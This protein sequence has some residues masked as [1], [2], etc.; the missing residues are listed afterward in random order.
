MSG[1]LPRQAQRGEFPWPVASRLV[2][3]PSMVSR[4]SARG[5]LERK[6]TTGSS[7]AAPGW[8]QGHGEWLRERPEFQLGEPLV[9][10]SSSVRGL[11]FQSGQP[12]GQ[13]SLQRPSGRSNSSPASSFEGELYRDRAGGRVGKL[14]VS[15]FQLAIPTSSPWSARRRADGAVPVGW[16][17]CSSVVSTPVCRSCGV[18]SPSQASTPPSPRPLFQRGDGLEN[19]RV[20]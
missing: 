17:L 1:R 7:S 16:P 19:G 11:K 14:Q 6:L 2:A 5:E 8:N 12:L 20:Q 9:P 10:G 3:V 13:S 18:R 15:S 4:R